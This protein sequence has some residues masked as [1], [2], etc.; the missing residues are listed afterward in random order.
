MILRNGLAFSIQNKHNLS[1]KIGNCLNCA[2]DVAIKELQVKASKFFIWTL[3]A[4][5]FWNGTLL[6]KYKKLMEAKST[7]NQ[8]ICFYYKNANIKLLSKFW[9]FFKTCKPFC[10][11]CCNIFFLWSFCYQKCTIL[12]YP[13]HFR[14][15]MKVVAMVLS[16]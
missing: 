11:Y 13:I 16:F 4:L 1:P 7:S 12:P 6:S 9:L 10:W 15:K 2:V 3:F 5:Q 8:W 14:E